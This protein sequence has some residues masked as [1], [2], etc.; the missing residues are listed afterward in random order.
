MRA[1]ILALVACSTPSPTRPSAPAENTRSVCA[2]EITRRTYD[3]VD[4]RVAFVDRVCAMGCSAGACNTVAK[5]T[6]QPVV[7]TNAAAIVAERDHVYVAGRNRIVRWSTSSGLVDVISELGGSALALDATHVYWVANDSILRAPRGGGPPSTVVAQREQ[8][9]ALAV[10]DAHVYWTE[11]DVNDTSHNGVWRIAK[12][13]GAIEAFG[14]QQRGANNLALDATDVYW[15]DQFEDRVMRKPKAGGTTEVI[16]TAQDGASRVVLDDVFVY[17]LATGEGVRRRKDGGAVEPVAA[18]GANSLAVV[19]GEVFST[20]ITGVRHGV[21]V[22][23]SAHA[24]GIVAGP[25]HLYWVT[26]YPERVLRVPLN[27]AR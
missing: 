23:A 8:I 9:F 19:A 16:A 12:Q 1:L 15:T 14:P 13:G 11:L 20:G 4:G 24:S 21:D 6:A 26:E 17:W 25:E 3:V 27:C 22:V 10:D 5:C 2:D 7:A 18:A